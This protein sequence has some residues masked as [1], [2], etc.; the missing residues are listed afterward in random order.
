MPSKEKLRTT[1][2]SAKK[3]KS[4]VVDASSLHTTQGDSGGPLMLESE[5]DRWVSVGI[6]SYGYRCAEPGKPGVY[7]RVASYL[8]W[9]RTKA[10]L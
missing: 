8:D 1:K 3:K 4:T 9:I 10:T 2:S 5:P 7:T 6:V